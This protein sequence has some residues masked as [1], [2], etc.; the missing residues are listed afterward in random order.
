MADSQNA[1]TNSN[2]DCS[3]VNYSQDGTVEVSSQ[4]STALEPMYY[5]LEEM[6]SRAALTKIE[7]L[8]NNFS[9]ST[10]MTP[11][12]VASLRAKLDVDGNVMEGFLYAP[13]DGDVTR[14]V[15]GRD[16]CY[17]HMTTQQQ[18]IAMIWHDRSVA[19]PVFRFWGP[20]FQVI[21]AM[22][23]IRHRI[24]MKLNPQ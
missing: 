22:N 13:S 19:R 5:K 15:I 24:H 3:E 12:F 6:T 4:S 9:P 10:K 16:G 11:E 20:K 8:T 21:K 17:F 23:I 7:G 2:A 14:Q 1:N 18:D